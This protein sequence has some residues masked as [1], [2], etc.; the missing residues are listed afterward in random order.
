[1]YVCAGTWVDIY[2]CVCNIVK[3]MIFEI[4]RSRK[5]YMSA[6]FE[7]QYASALHRTNTILE[8]KIQE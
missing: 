3:I 5:H 4:I 6:M 2:E 8:K 1:M 7:N